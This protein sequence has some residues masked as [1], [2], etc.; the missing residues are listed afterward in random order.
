MIVNH[1]I[2]FIAVICILVSRHLFASALAASTIRIRFK[3][4]IFLTKFKFKLS[5]IHVVVKNN[6][7]III[8]SLICEETEVLSWLQDFCTT[9]APPAKLETFSSPIGAEILTY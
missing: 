9:S 5:C 4:I 6:N 7:K 3:L 8:I 1:R 2:L